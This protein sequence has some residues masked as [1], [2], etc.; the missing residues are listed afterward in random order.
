MGIGCLH[1]F[2]INNNIICRYMYSPL[3]IIEA[4]NKFI[5]YYTYS[6]YGEC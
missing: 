3:V 1:I 6:I 5:N 2:K 4:C